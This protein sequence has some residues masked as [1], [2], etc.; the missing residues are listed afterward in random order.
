VKREIEFTTLQAEREMRKKTHRYEAL[1][2]PMDLYI[3]EVQRV[4]ARKAVVPFTLQTVTKPEVASFT[5]HGVMAMEGTADEVDDWIT[6]QGGQPP[7]VWQDVYQAAANVIA[8]MAK[9]L[10]IPFPTPQIGGITVGR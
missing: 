8:V 4:A 7:K 1:E 10:E 9:V 6:P 2:Y 5:V 3:Q